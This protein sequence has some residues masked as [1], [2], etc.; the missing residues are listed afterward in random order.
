MTR[1]PV[2]CASGAEL[3]VALEGSPNADAAF[4]LIDA[5]GETY[6]GPVPMLETEPGVYTG[7]YA[8]ADGDLLEDGRVKAELRLS[9]GKT[10]ERISERP[11]RLDA[12]PPPAVLG[13]SVQDA[14]DDEGGALLLNWQASMPARLDTAFI[15]RGIRSQS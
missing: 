12:E 15:C 4:S 1:P 5:D 9:N 3:N 7:T 2:R 11:A 14:P 6:R 10:A 8:P 13:V